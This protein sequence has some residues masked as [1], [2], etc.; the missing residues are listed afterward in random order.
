[1]G[2]SILMGVCLAL[3]QVFIVRMFMDVFLGRHNQ[4]VIHSVSCALYFTFLV[5][6]NLTDIFSPIVLVS[7]NIV[8]IAL[9][10]FVDRKASVKSCCFFSILIFTVWM[11][12]EVGAVIIAE[13]FGIDYTKH[14]DIVSVVSQLIML[15]LAF[16]SAKYLDRDSYGSIPLKYFLMILTI[17]VISI[18][19]MNEIYVIASK[20][21]EYND[22]AIISSFFLM[23]INYI[24]FEVY[25]WMNRD[26]ELKSQNRLYGQ[27]LELCARQAE[28]K[29]QLYLEIRRTRHDMKSHL[30]GLLGMIESGETEEASKYI[31]Q[32]L[33][34]GV[35]KSS[36]EISRS[37][38]IVIDSLVNY[39]NSIA[40]KEGIAF[41][42]S[43]FVPASLP[44]KSEHLVIILGNLLENAFDACKKVPPK[45]RYIKLDMGFEK[46]MLTISIKNSCILEKR[47][48]KRGNFFSTKHDAENHGIGLTSVNHT[49]KGYDG[50]VVTEDKGNQ[51]SVSVVMYGKEE[52]LKP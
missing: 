46:N 31:S 9:L 45:G 3:L 43:V 34:D 44:F 18:F 19:L 28:E 36:E 41:E 35:G 6:A 5:V 33:A 48:D 12:V 7:V 29:E 23:M 24:I 21:D 50:E 1:M 26:S 30:S 25:T 49:V 39:K 47:R 16:I 32:L 10:G 17:P 2:G 20:H 37:G 11:L 14:E 4:V 15:L 8:S 22:F 52:E 40:K 51:F 27:Q 13:K 38:N 42:A